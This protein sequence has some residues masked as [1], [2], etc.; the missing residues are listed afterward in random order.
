MSRIARVITIATDVGEDTDEAHREV[1]LNFVDVDARQV[2]QTRFARVL[3][4]DILRARAI[5][6][7]GN[8]V[9]VDVVRGEDD[10]VPILTTFHTKAIADRNAMSTFGGGNVI[11]LPSLKV[12]GIVMRAPRRR[13]GGDF[14]RRRYRCH[15]SHHGLLRVKTRFMPAAGR[16]AERPGAT[17]LTA[18][19]CSS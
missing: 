17:T 15:R 4:E 8:A 11:V 1:N 18:D 5:P 10:V 13:G 19:A 7:F 12:N 6:L 16:L 2:V 14:S 9:N 3:G